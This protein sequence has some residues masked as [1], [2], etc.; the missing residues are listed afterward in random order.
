[1]SDSMGAV[2]SDT[3]GPGDR[4]A[5]REPRAAARA[6]TVLGDRGALGPPVKVCFISPLSYG[7]YRPDSGLPFGGAEVQFF[8][9]SRAIAGHERREVTVL[10]TVP[11]GQGE[12]REQ[13]GRVT[14][15]TREGK[16]RLSRAAG[17][18]LPARAAG[19]ASAFRDMYRQLRAIDADVYLHAGAG[20]EVGAYAV[21]SRLLGKRFV[22]VVASSADLGWPQE[23]SRGSLPWLY[24]LGLKLAHVLVCRTVEQQETLR[25]LYR[26][27]GILIRT[28][29]PC[30]GAEDVAAAP[31]RH[32]LW[33]GRLHPLKQPDLFLDLAERLPDERFVMAAMK[34]ARH[35]DLL[36]RV[37]RRA[38]ALPQVT[39][40]E[41]L[42]LD[43]MDR[44]MAEAM[45]FVNTSTYEG[46]P[47]TF[48]QATM[49]AVPILSWRVDPDGVLTRQGIGICAGSSFEQLAAEASRFC[50]D[51]RLR[52]ETG[53]RARR[54]A[55][56]HHDLNRVAQAWNDLFRGCVE[57]TR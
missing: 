17:S 44:V 56:E 18:G 21:I 27:S 51:E 45:L 42:P 54:Y 22:F 30:P 11:Q 7:L 1:M 46:F 12:G 25:R 36:E 55:A 2:Q 40:R 4:L 33:A 13:Q 14:I 47:N 20:A 24:R 39:L 50:Q 16:G 35:A 53:A 32:I 38:A 57:G 8:L 26:R 5:G 19:Y 9:V 15:V 43:Q 34:D 3:A 48:V 10:T 41:D 31:R 29:H 23:E 37:R 52:R 6:G 49:Q 28:A